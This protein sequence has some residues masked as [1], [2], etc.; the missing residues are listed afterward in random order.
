[1]MTTDPGLPGASRRII[2]RPHRKETIMR[3]LL[4]SVVLLLAG[5][6]G[7]GTDIVGKSRAMATVCA[8]P[9]DIQGA[10][11]A[12]QTHCEAFDRNAELV[13]VSNGVLGSNEEC[14]SEDGSYTGKIVH[15]RCVKE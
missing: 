10:I 9:N 8:K 11:D 15:F 3:I 13:N 4:C 14:K 6:S 12:A 5:C 7:S 1:M 2:L